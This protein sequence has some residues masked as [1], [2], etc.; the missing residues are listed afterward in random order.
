[1][2]IPLDTLSGWVESLRNMRA[3]F[4]PHIFGLLICFLSITGS[5]E[6]LGLADYGG[7]ALEAGSR[8]SGDLI[9]LKA[10]HGLLETADD[11]YA[12]ADGAPW[13]DSPPARVPQPSKCVIFLEH[14]DAKR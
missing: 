7:K 9:A 12:W 3:A 5:L 11:R 6:E 4:S 1:M 10:S 13:A 2:P 8:S 14:G